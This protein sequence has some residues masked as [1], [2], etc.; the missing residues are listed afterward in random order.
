M[1]SSSQNDP[2]QVGPLENLWYNYE[3]PTLQKN[4]GIIKVVGVDNF[5]PV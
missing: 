3:F 2:H 5:Y 4:P 1:I